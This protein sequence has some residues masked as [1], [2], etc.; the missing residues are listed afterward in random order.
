MRERLIIEVEVRDVNGKLYKDKYGDTIV[1]VLK[2]EI[3]DYG[4]NLTELACY[5]IVDKFEAICKEGSKI[6]IEVRY[7]DEIT[8]TYPLL[9]SFYGAERK[10]VKH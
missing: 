1:N 10:F 2:F 4:E 9:Y 7:L 3:K 6:N 8:N 5:N